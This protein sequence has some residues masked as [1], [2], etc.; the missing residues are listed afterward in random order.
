MT[1][2]VTLLEVLMALTILGLAVVALLQLSA[3]GLRL[4]GQAGDYQ[5]AVMVA[6]RVARSTDSLREGIEVGRDGPFEWERR[7]AAV[8]V[9]EALTP[10]AGPHPHLYALTVAVRWGR[11]RTLAL[12]SLRTV[13]DTPDP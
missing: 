12:A 3:Q 13:T 1:R 5:A 10:G 7:V 9:P 6:D 11:S 4:L 8:P 2:G